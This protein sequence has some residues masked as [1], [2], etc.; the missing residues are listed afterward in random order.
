MIYL[1]LSIDISLTFERC[2]SSNERSSL[3]FDVKSVTRS[4]SAS[5]W[6]TRSEYIES[7]FFFEVFFSG[8]YGERGSTSGISYPFSF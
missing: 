4:F 5:N 7:S 3:I 2:S 1:S 8:E 6:S